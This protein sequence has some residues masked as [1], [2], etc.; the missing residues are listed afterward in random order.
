MPSREITLTENTDTS[1]N[2]VRTR[3]SARAPTIASSPTSA[4]IEAATR[5]PKIRRA[6]S[7]TTGIEISSAR[8]RSSLVISL[9]SSKTA[10]APATS[11]S[12]PVPGS[13][14]SVGASSS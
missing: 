5:L 1:V 4:G 11:V 14:S 7:R 10:K 13:D 6:S 12:T 9:T 8:L 3:T 2:R